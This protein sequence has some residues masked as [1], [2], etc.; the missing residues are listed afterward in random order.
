[1]LPP[2]GL[3][4]QRERTQ[5]LQVKEGIMDLGSYLI[6]GLGNLVRGLGNSAVP[7]YISLLKGAVQIIVCKLWGAWC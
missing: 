7:S 4:K 5:S 2:P 1:M 3:N 6:R